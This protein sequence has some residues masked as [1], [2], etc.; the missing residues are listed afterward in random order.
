MVL[1]ETALASSE[2]EQSAGHPESLLYPTKVFTAFTTEPQA[3]SQ[4]YDLCNQQ[5]N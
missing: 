3:M 1:P 2:T 4:V 5:S